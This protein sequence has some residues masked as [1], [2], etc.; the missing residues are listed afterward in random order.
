MEMGV[1]L[2]G[3]ACQQSNCVWRYTVSTDFYKVGNGSSFFKSVQAEIEASTDGTVRVLAAR[4]K[5]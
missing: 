2:N 4:I 1:I 5:E 3:G